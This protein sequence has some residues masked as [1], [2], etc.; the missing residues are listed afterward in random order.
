MDRRAWTLLV[1]LAAIWGASYM[2]IEI[3]LRD[4]SPAMVAWSRIAL[5]AVVLVAI[6][7]ARGALRGLGARV[8]DAGAGRARSRW[9]GRSC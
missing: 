4:L 2:F 1:M 8:A 7:A 9:P 3:G 5:A 6:A